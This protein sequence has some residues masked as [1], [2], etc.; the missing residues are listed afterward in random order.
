MDKRKERI[1]DK[2]NFDLSAGK[3]SINMGGKKKKNRRE[4]DTIRK[5]TKECLKDWRSV[6]FDEDIS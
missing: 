1:E 3:D 5:I 2:G 4:I 6:D